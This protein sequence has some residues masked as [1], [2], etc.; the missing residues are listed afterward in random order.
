VHVEAIRLSKDDWDRLKQQM[1]SSCS[2]ADESPL[3]SMLERLRE[4]APLNREQVVATKVGLLSGK[5]G[6]RV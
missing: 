3:I 4:E 2:P 1:L 5:R 6:S